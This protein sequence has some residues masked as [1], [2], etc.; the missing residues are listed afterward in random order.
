[1]FYYGV[2]LHFMEQAVKINIFFFLSF[3]FIVSDL[4]HC[5]YVLS[6]PHFHSYVF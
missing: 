4:R 1:V 5:G 3:V 6:V 2:T